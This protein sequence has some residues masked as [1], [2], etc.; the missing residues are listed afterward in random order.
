MN[1]AIQA[2]ID[3]LRTAF[4]PHPLDVQSAFE[5]WG[6]TYID[7]A[8]FKTEAHG[9]RWDELSPRFLEFHHDALLFL[10]PSVLTEVIPAYLATALRRDQELDM[11]PRFLISVLMR[12]DDKDRERFEAR[13]G[14]L[15]PA[16]RQAIAHA[17]EAWEQSF[18]NPDRRRPIT[19]A[20]ESYWRGTRSES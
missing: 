8:R 7:G 2:A 14:P 12:G 16:Q 6:V 3:E 15:P 1:D 11:L 18:E 20:L 17:L 4:P 19:D 13:F 5:D 9:K 10:E